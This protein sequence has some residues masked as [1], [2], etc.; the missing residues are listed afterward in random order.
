MKFRIVPTTLACPACSAL[1]PDARCPE[2][3][4][5]NFVLSNWSSSLRRSPDAG[6][7]TSEDWPS[8]MHTQMAKICAR[9]ECRVLVAI[10]E[11][12]PVF[13]GFIAGEPTERVVYFVFV[14]DHFRRSGLARQLFKSLGIDPGGRFV[15]PCRTYDSLD[16]R[17]RT[18]HAVHDRAVGRYAKADRHRSYAR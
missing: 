3:C 6:M 5:R 15:Y 2:R 12:A 17:D 16:L 18:P 9:P 13:G 1:A 14:K 4:A 8:V 10:G 11:A 7:I